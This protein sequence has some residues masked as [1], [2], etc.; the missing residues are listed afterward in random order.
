MLAGGIVLA[1]VSVHLIIMAVSYFA[2]NGGVNGLP[3]AEMSEATYDTVD[4]EGNKKAPD[5]V[6]INDPGNEF[7]TAGKETVVPADKKSEQW[8]D[9]V[10]VWPADAKANGAYT[11]DEYAGVYTGSGSTN[12]EEDDEGGTKTTIT[13]IKENEPD[14]TESFPVSSDTN[15][16][17]REGNDISDQIWKDDN[18]ATYNGFT[19]TDTLADASGKMGTINIPSIGV[20][21][22]VYESL[23]DEME[24]M[25]KGIAHFAE[26]SGWDG[27]VG[28]CA[29]NWTESGNG[30]YFKNLDSVS[31]GDTIT[32]ATSLGTRTY[33][34]VT[35]EIIAEDNFDYLARTD[36]NRLTL[37]TCTFSDSSKRLVVQAVA[38]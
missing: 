8:N 6:K 10:P 2:H 30:A 13:T 11:A 33:K 20:S 18:V 4:Y 26:T 38:Q 14:S 21:A 9:S 1:V 16:V 17:K 25:T 37:I 7:A 23:T 34:V 15:I 27:N 22:G 19:T 31:K 32:Y 12:E 29:H 24:A 35:K 5:D 36:D 28:V 3:D